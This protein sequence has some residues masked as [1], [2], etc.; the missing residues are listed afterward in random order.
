MTPE[1]MISRVDIRS[2]M[3]SAIAGNITDL[4]TGTRDNGHG[5]GNRAAL[6]AA[7]LQN[8]L[9]ASFAI[10]SLSLCL[11]VYVAAL[12]LRLIAA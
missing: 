8:V 7:R 6:A 12:S 3:R 10:G 11:V 2:Q 4:R 1:D 9:A 5:F